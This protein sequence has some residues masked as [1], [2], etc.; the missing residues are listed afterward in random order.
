M[1]DL[2]AKVLALKERLIAIAKD[3]D[4]YDGEL[5]TQREF[6]DAILDFKTLSY[7]TDKDAPIHQEI[8][9]IVNYGEKNYGNSAIDFAEPIIWLLEKFLR[10]NSEL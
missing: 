9:S 10:Y 8:M 2:Q 4:S 5:D 3:C 1:E 7:K 6:N